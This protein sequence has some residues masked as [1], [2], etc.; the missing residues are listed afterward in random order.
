MRS[1]VYGASRPGPESRLQNG[2]WKRGARCQDHAKDEALQLGRR[3]APQQ[4]TK[5]RKK[6]ERLMLVCH[7]DQPL[8]SGAPTGLYLIAMF[9]KEVLLLGPREEARLWWWWVVGVC[10]GGILRFPFPSPP[11]CLDR[12]Q[13]PGPRCEKESRNWFVRLE[14]RLN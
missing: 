5:S 13:T 8:A 4:V 6:Y 11:H 3:L 10:D 12:Q 7:R 2:G 1:K 9:L 14:I